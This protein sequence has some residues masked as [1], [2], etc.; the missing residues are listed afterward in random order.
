M[1]EPPDTPAEAKRRRLR[2]ISIAEL[3]GVLAVGI[4]ALSYWDAHRERVAAQAPAP[5]APLL[6]TATADAEGTRLVL[7]PARGESVI[8]TQTL[9]F[10]EALRSDPVETTGN[11]RIE[12]SWIE[13][14]LRRAVD[15]EA[16]TPRIPV[17]I[18]TTFE[19][20][21]DI[22]RDAALYD[23]G[24]NFHQRL[25]RSRTVQLEGIT[26]V[27]RVPAEKLKAAVEARWMRVAPKAKS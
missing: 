8:Q 16:G 5:A 13:A 24:Y 21:G 11:S 9:T 27:S 20:G 19:N 6:L 4:S 3:V 1:S 17:G 12:A 25:L 10:P 2:L 14:G 15:D 18:V 7:R 23:V 22:K 26:L